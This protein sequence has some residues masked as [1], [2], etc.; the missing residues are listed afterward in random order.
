MNKEKNNDVF[1]NLIKFANNPELWEKNKNV[2]LNILNKDLQRKEFIE[3]HLSENF[4]NLI[5]NSKLLNSIQ[6]LIGYKIING[7]EYHFILK[8]NFSERKDFN[9]NIYEFEVEL[10]NIATKPKVINKKKLKTIFNEMLF[11]IGYEIGYTKGVIER[12]DLDLK[13]LRNEK[14]S[15]VINESIQDI[16]KIF[17]DYVC[18][19]VKE[20]NHL[21]NY[22]FPFLNYCLENHLVKTQNGFFQYIADLLF[23]KTDVKAVKKTFLAH[24]KKAKIPKLW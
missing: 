4:V 5:P 12:I 17:F 7:D 21:Y 9:L 1:F 13:I 24:K 2:M 15:L 6:N 16:Q 10:K 14:D 19:I 3:K 8:H 11:R 20:Q 23:N 18:N 22:L